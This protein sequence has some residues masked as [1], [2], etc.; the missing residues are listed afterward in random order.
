MAYTADWIREYPR[1]TALKGSGCEWVDHSA[2]SR[3]SVK[4]R[5]AGLGDILDL[6]R[7]Q[8]SESTTRLRMLAGWSRW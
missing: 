8:V 6:Q 3:S 2:I 1:R 4:P 5:R 7:E